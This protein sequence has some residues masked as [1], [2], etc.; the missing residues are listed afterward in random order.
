MNNH[1]DDDGHTGHSHDHDHDHGHEHS[2]DPVDPAAAPDGEIRY[3]DHGTPEPRSLKPRQTVENPE[4]MAEQLVSP[5][6]RGRESKCTANCGNG[7]CGS[8]GGA[9]MTGGCG[10]TSLVEL[11]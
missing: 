1:I 6:L 11:I 8:D 5:T 2:H 9:C 4:N 7:G 3:H 10:T